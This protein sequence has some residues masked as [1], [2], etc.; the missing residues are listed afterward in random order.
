MWRMPPAWD[1]AGSGLSFGAS[2]FPGETAVAAVAVLAF[3]DQ[4][5]NFL[6]P[7]VV[8]RNSQN[9]SRRGPLTH[10]HTA[11]AANWPYQMAA[12]VLVTL[13]VLVV[14]LLAQRYVTQGCAS[15]VRRR[16]SSASRSVR[17]SRTMPVCRRPGS[18][19]TTPCP[20]SRRFTVHCDVRQHARDAHRARG[21]DGHGYAA[22]RDSR[23]ARGGCASRRPNA[24]EYIDRALQRCAASSR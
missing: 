16:V 22:R 2:H 23:T 12:A 6:W 13:P 15:R 18:H 19:S 4:W 8:T 3:M 7:L 10:F 1:G 24:L 21:R 17:T 11:Y 9:G 5:R 20:V 14:C